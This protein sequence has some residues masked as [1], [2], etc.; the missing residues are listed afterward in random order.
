MM[1]NHIWRRAIT[2][3]TVLLLSLALPMAAFAHP[4][5]NFTINHYAGLNVSREMITIDYV[6]DMAEIPAFQ[7]I[8]LFD[9]NGNGQPDSAETT[10]YHSAKCES[11]RSDLDLRVNKRSAILALS[12]S[13]I[14]FPPGAGGLPTLRLTCN[15]NTPLTNETTNISFADNAYSERL[16]WREIVL[17]GDDVGLQGEFASTSLSQRLTAYP[18]DMLSSP[19]DQ[20]EISFGVDLMSASGTSPAAAQGDPSLNTTR[21]DAFTQL[22][23]LEKLTLPAILFALGISF[24]WGAMH[25]MTPGH[26]KTIVGAYLVGSRGTMKHA[27]YLGLTTTITHTLGVFA[28]G[29]VTL[30]AA[31]YIVP[32][33]LYPWMGLLSG[34]FV[35]GIGL[36]LFFQR[37]KSSGVRGW[38]G[39]LKTNHPVLRPAYSPALQSTKTKA[40][41]HKHRFVL[42]SAYD[43]SHSHGH[44]HPHDHDHH[45]DHGHHHDHEHGNHDHD[46]G[47]A[48]HSHMP[49]QEITWRSLLALGISG[50]LIP[51]PSALVVMLGAI[52][53]NRIGFGL[54]LVLVF[55]LG[56]ASALTAIGMLFIYAGRL[57]E[58]FPSQGRIIQLLPILSALFVSAIGVGITLKALAELGIV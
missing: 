18:D 9:A 22:I 50:G 41:E 51:C 10:P 43:H 2:I 20:R 19:L 13:S 38:F 39:R 49:P 27:L 35:A 15:F 56:L 14:E 25:A 29:L 53:L 26:G 48:D 12:S 42:A 23:T 57:F 11:I 52:A 32:E 36:N 40:P 17:T 4:L 5:G 31:Q 46:H 8:A 54:I 45:A 34:L 1:N 58:R 55:S 30:F 21:E 37:F 3:I 28:L 44:V 6:L 16:G 7:E 33:K 47:H 24:V